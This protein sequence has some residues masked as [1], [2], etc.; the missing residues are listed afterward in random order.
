VKRK[1][2]VL[3]AIA[4]TLI[5]SGCASVNSAAKVGKV[6]ITLNTVESSINDVLKERRTF[7]TTNSN[8]PTGKEL[9]LN[10][11]RFH[12]ISALFDA[13]AKGAQ[14]NINDGDIAKQ[15]ALIISQLGS[16]DKLPGA[17]VN[18]SLAKKD[19]NRY[20]RTVIIA[21]K[22]TEIVKASG[23]TSTDGSGVQKLLIAAGKHEGVTINPKYGVWNYTSGSIDAAAP[24]SA[25]K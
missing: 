2:L 23:D 16:E 3:V 22:M 20:L 13:L 1:V 5:L 24:N 6:E 7:D 21:N 10:I 9:N 14:L 17:L 15:R 12:V 25:V 8:L 19:F 4:S 11:V 18:A